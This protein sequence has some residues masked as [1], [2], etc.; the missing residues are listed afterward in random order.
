MIY[1][2]L[3]TEEP[4]NTQINAFFADYENLK[5]GYFAPLS[6]PEVKRVFYTGVAENEA[7][8]STKGVIGTVSAGENDDG[9]QTKVTSEGSSGSKY[10]AK[11]ENNYNTTVSGFAVGKNYIAFVALDN[12]GNAA[13]DTVTIKEENGSYTTYSNISI[14]VDTES[15]I[16]V[17]AQSGQQYTNGVSQISVNGT[18]SDLPDTDSSGVQS[19]S[20]TL[21]G[22][23]AEAV[24]YDANGERTVNSENEYTWT[25]V[26]PASTINTLTQGKSYNVNGSITDGAGNTSS[27]TLF[28]LSFDK[29]APVVSVSSPSTAAKI[30]GKMALSGQ[31]ESE[32]SAPVSLAL[33][34]SKT[35]PGTTAITDT[36][37]FTKVKEI[38]DNVIL[39]NSLKI[40][41]RAAVSEWKP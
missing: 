32:G 6:E 22:I 1:Y 17:C 21:N 8:P 12:A 41:S 19:I 34:V 33:Y 23:E 14:N 11:I 10:Y 4:D 40:V 16:L 28:T 5:T 24:I 18:Y 25:A 38:T 2:K 20:V 7:V 30:N 9:A 26:I 27:S 39:N 37:K 36:S 35:A 3:Y 31:V 29:E 13:K 15:P